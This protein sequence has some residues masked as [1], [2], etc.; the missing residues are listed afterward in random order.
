[1]MLMLMMMIMIL[2]ICK[3][4]LSYYVIYLLK[5]S[6]SVVARQGVVEELEVLINNVYGQ[7]CLSRPNHYK[8]E[9]HLGF[10]SLMTLAQT[11]LPR[12]YIFSKS[13]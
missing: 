10:V 9:W 13:I 4:Y 7:K 1:M 2:L 3:T 11:N 8:Y 5:V 6:I 12:G